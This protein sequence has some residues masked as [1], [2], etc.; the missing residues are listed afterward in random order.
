MPFRFA[1]IT[2]LLLAAA[3]H[4]QTLPRVAPVPPTK[5]D[6][7]V[8]I[9]PGG[10]I[11]VTHGART[12]V[13]ASQYSLMPGWAKLG[14]QTNENFDAVIIDGESLSAETA[15][16]AISRRLVQHDECIEVVDTLTNM[17]MDKLPL[18][19]RHL[20]TIPAPN[21]CYLAGYRVAGAAG[22][23]S[24]AANATTICTTADGSLG[25]LA[26]DDVFRVHIQSLASKTNNQY[27]LSDSSLVLAP[28]AT[29]T[30]RWAVFPNAGN[31][32]FDCLNAMRRFMGVNFLIDGSFTFAYP[33]SN[34]PPQWLTHP[35]YGPQMR[36]FSQDMP[37]EDMRKLFENRSVK[38]VCSSRTNTEGDAGSSWFYSAE[39]EAHQAFFA[40]IR[41]A[42]PDAITMYYYH[43]F[44][45]LASGVNGRFQDCR[46]M[47]PDGTQADYRD[48]K[49]PLFFPVIG[50]EWADVM[51]QRFDL[52]LDEFKVDGIYWDEFAHS[53]AATHYGEPWDGVTGD[54]DPVTHELIDTHS[55]IPLLTLPWRAQRVQQLIDRGKLLLV[56][57]SVFTETMTNMMRKH[58]FTGFT[59]TGTI[60]NLNHTHLFTPIALGN[61]LTETTE[62]SCYDNMVEGLTYGGL[63][64]WYG[65]HTSTTYP[66]LTKYMFPITPVELHDGYIIGKERI[67]TAR[68]GW[69]S[70]GDDRSATPHFFDRTGRE[71]EGEIIAVRQ[72]DKVYYRVLLDKN[73]SCV[74]VAGEANRETLPTTFPPDPPPPAPEVVET[75]T[76]PTGQAAIAIPASVKNMA[77][78]VNLRLVFKP[79][80]P[81][82]IDGDITDWLPHPAPIV[83]DERYVAQ[84]S[85]NK[86]SGPDDLSGTCWY[87][88]DANYLYFAA[89]VRD[90]KIVV[91][92]GGGD[93]YI[94]DHIELDF[95]PH[96][97]PDTAGA[98]GDDQTIIALTP[99]NLVNSGDAFTDIAPQAWIYAPTSMAAEG[100][101]VGAK[102][103]EAGYFLEA[104]IPWSVLKMTPTKGGAISMDVHLSDTD[105]PGIQEAYTTFRAVKWGIRNRALLLP[106][107]LGDTAGE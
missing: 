106:V 87:F 61:S 105:N 102:R 62:A 7:N 55:A 64:Y 82:N 88:W 60:S 65:D 15:G 59:E 16:F 18:M 80:P 93:M 4:A 56:N 95:D 36:R 57:G 74:L 94:T 78:D 48:P 14:E 47:K 86:W 10:A 92:R 20:A 76:A 5:V 66:T 1:A 51:E 58:R 40:K 72:G 79:D 103:T 98:F 24:M 39:V 8:Q 34:N 83:I 22:R 43:C 100:I 38:F 25:M 70:F 73:E 11:A 53:A 77:D 71:T 107:K 84:F 41:E 104:R 45:E 9:T 97:P 29:Y 67:I 2:T 28:G 21:E 89:D 35:D 50:N 3:A 63:Y 6:Y 90:D 49:Y 31:R 46:I 33:R 101:Q 75:V 44:D 81:I 54:I 23:Q 26:L 68:S 99:G 13:I 12:T 85:K 42:A 19:V 30:Q 52:I 96:Y 32:Y 17:T 69:Y 91:D 27:G 37:V